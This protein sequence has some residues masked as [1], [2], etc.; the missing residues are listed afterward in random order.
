MA[1]MLPGFYAELA[2]PHLLQNALELK[3]QRNAD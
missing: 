3:K 1:R 2:Q